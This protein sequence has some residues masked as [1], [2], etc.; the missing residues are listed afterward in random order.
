M[1]EIQSLRNSLYTLDYKK[2]AEHELAI[3][4]PKESKIAMLLQP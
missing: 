4:G 2:R 3:F 1:N